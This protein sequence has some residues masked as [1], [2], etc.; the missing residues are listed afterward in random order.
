MSRPCKL[1]FDL[2][3]GVRVTCDAGYLCANFSLVHSVLD[4]DPYARQTDVRRASSLH[5][6]CPYPRDFGD[7]DISISYTPN[8]GDVSPSLGIDATG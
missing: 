3:N 6:S 1:T 4:L 2:A 5:V 8:F 7:V